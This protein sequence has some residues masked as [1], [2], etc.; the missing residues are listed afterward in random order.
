MADVSRLTALGMAPELAVEVAAQIESAIADDTQVAAL[1]SLT[2]NT[3]GTPS[4][5]LAD[6]PGTYTEATLANQLSSL[7]VKVNAIIAALKT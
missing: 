5:T 4:N 3:G 6:V 2:D 7:A 1:V